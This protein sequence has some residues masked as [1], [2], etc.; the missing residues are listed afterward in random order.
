MAI[1]LVPIK[2]LDKAT[3]NG[4]DTD[5]VV[6]IGD[7]TNSDM[8]KVSVLDLFDVFFNSQNGEI[9]LT[10]TDTVADYSSLPTGLDGSNVGEIYIT[11]DDGMGYIWDGSSFPAQGQGLNLSPDAPHIKNGNWWLGSTDTGVRAKGEDGATPEIKNGNWWIAG[12]DTGVAAKG[13]KGDDGDTPSINAAGNWEIGAT[14]TG[15]RA[16]M[17]HH[18]DYTDD[19]SFQ[20]GAEDAEI[21]AT[22]EYLSGTL[23]VFID[24]LLKTPGPNDSF[25]YKEKGDDKTV[26]IYGTIEDDTDIK[27]RY[28]PQTPIS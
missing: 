24:G 19:L 27:F 7:D 8:Y 3:Q 12:V 11:Q 21:E 6:P 22:H 4:Y 9:S 28:I 15:V 14:D 1:Q 13:E 23:Q 20:V 26:K 17:M 10:I 25:D 18:T 16:D 5:W 2:D